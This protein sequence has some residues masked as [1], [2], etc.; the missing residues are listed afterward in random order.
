M[1]FATRRS[2]GR[3]TSRG[4]KAAEPASER[5]LLEDLV[6]ANRILTRE[7]GI[8]D[9]PAHVSARSQTNPNHWSMARFVALGGASL[10]DMIE[11]DL[12]STPVKGPRNDNARET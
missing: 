10:S 7:V 8:L 11:Y 9:I 6:L 4:S 1:F 3:H 5:A 2:P 12:E